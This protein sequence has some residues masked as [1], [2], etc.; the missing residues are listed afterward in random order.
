MYALL[1]SASSTSSSLWV[2]WFCVSPLLL[3]RP[4]APFSSTMESTSFS[5]FP[6]LTPS[7]P[8][9]PSAFPTSSHVLNPPTS[10]KALLTCTMR[11]PKPFSEDELSIGQREWELSLID[12]ALGKWPY[13][14]LLAAIKRKW[15]LKG[16][17]DLLTLVGDFLYKFSYKEDFDT[18]WDSGPTHK[19]FQL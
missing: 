7:S 17:L 3:R 8:T 10:W 12:H 11:A 19:S 4:E 18:V 6:A 13:E 14:T 1:V 2:L 15:T 16:S 9:I 5:D